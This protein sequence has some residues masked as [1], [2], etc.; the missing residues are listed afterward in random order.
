VTTVWVVAIDLNELRLFV[1]GQFADRA[2]AVGPDDVATAF[3]LPAAEA[4]DALRALDDAHLLVLDSGRQRIV[5]AHPWAAMPM[6]FVVASDTQKWWG[7]CAWDSFAIPSLVRAPC[8]VATH[9]PACGRVLALDVHA[10]APPGPSS[11]SGQGTGEMVAHLPVPVARMWDDVVLTCS[12]QLLFCSRG[13]VA[14][15][16]ARTGTREGAVLSLDA[17]WN[18]AAGWY[19]GRL[20]PGY[21]RRTPAEAAGFFEDIGLT[22]DFWAS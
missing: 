5:M 16:L 4:L 18:L 21:R 12:S 7:G 6:G 8:L 11:G 10:D 9:C 3:G 1:Y 2:R 13:H 20:S 22:G 14:D 19:A 15:W 17:L